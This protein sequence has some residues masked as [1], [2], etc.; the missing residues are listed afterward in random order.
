MIRGQTESSVKFVGLIGSEI[1]YGNGGWEITDSFT[2]EVLA[3]MNGP[4]QIPLGKN[5][6]YFPI[7]KCSDEGKDYRTLIFHKYIEQPG[8]YCCNDGTCFTSHLVCDGAQHCDEGEDEQNC[9][10]IEV[11]RSYSKMVPPSNV[12]VDF[13]IEEILGI[14]DN[15]ATLDLNFRIHTRW[16]DTDL[17]FHYLKNNVHRHIN[18]VPNNEITRIWVPKINFAH[19]RDSFDS[20]KKE[21]LFIERKHSPKMSG[22]L[23]NLNV[24]EVY[25]GNDNPLYQHSEHNL[26]FFCN[27]DGVANYPFVTQACSFHFYLEGRANDE[28]EIYPNLKYPGKYSVGTSIGQYD[29][30]GWKIENRATESKNVT[31]ITISLAIRQDNIIMMNYIP[32]LLMNIINQAT[33]YITGDSKYDLIITVNI[34]SM[35]VLATIYMSV[36]MSLPN[37]PDIKPVEV[38]LFFSIAY[39]FW[40]IITNV[41][42]QVSL[43]CKLLQITLFISFI[44]SGL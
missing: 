8:H 32:A 6:W 13:N 42:M 41:V 37:T 15:D 33:N 39:P 11:P 34:T 7:S 29:I 5:Q 4:S 43:N 17:K 9:Q 30:I 1:K 18:S 24:S 3:Y 19:V 26:R 10:L 25:N 16:F 44:S 2:N 12:T 27:F 38:W 36:S 22:D 23:D 21:K 40:V 31:T 20:E 14:N 35:V 28:T